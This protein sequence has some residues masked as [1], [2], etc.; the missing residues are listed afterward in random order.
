MV[1]PSFCYAALLQTQKKLVS[2]F[3]GWGFPALLAHA[4]WLRK[5]LDPGAFKISTAHKDHSTHQLSLFPSHFPLPLT[6]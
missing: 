6:A 5:G 2:A 3:P 4:D 1:W